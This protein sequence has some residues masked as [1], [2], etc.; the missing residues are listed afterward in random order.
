MDRPMVVGVSARRQIR[1]LASVVD[2]DDSHE[3]QRVVTTGSGPGCGSLAGACGRAMS[4]R[5]AARTVG[6]SSRWGAAPGS[7]GGCSGRGVCRWG[8]DSAPGGAD[9]GRP[10]S[11]AGSG[12]RAGV[13]GPESLGGPRW[14]RERG[15]VD[16]LSKEAT[17]WPLARRRGSKRGTGQGP[18]ISCEGVFTLS[19]FRVRLTEKKAPQKRG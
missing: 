1:V 18:G 14:R 7:C 10:G 17:P 11:G 3:R 9:E 6:H 8:G 4:C 15:G 12:R 19:R 2:H 16:V 5:A 13:A